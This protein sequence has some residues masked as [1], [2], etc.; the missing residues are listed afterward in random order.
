VGNWGSEPPRR[1]RSAGTPV[2]PRRTAP[3]R[4][5]AYELFVA[6]HGD[7]TRAEDCW[8][9]AEEE[10]QARGSLLDAVVASSSARDDHGSGPL[11]ASP[12][13]RIE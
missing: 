7:A 2:D 12:D 11:I 5:R 8:H 13:R 3:I 6:A 9:R 1:R 4:A 10:A